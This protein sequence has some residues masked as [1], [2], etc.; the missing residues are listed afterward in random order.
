M[1]RARNITS[2]MIQDNPMANVEMFER[3]VSLGTGAFITLKG[4]TNIF[5]H[6]WIAMTEFAVGGTLLYRGITGNCPVKE[7]FENQPDPIS[8]GAM[9]TEAY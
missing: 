9:P 8:A 3:Y 7:R 2:S 4:V 5:A 1:N 6:P